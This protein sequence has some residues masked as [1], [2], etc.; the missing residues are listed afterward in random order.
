[1]T[2]AGHT[3]QMPSCLSTS[4]QL[5]IALPIPV[6]GTTMADYF[7]VPMLG[8][9]AIALL[10]LVLRWS[11]QPPKSDQGRSRGPV[12]GEHGMLV[13]VVSEP[14]ESEAREKARQLA[15]IG[16]RATVSPL[17]AEHLVLVWPWQAQA[18]RDCLA[19]HRGR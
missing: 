18:A 8:L 2:I 9:L 6:A 14:E 10:V 11:H 5:E 1:M 13:P 15:D 19:R 12:V 16:I 3:E 7:V 4:S 17:R